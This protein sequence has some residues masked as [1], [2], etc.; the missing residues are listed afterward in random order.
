MVSTANARRPRIRPRSSLTPMAAMPPVVRPNVMARA[1]SR[2]GSVGVGG[3]ASGSGAAMSVMPAPSRRGNGFAVG[4]RDLEEELL[5]VARRPGEADDG[6]AL[7]D[8]VGQQAGA[9][10][11]VAA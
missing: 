3:A 10:G 6:Q 11:I 2:P 4:R 7:A 9:R 5:E 8:H 1:R